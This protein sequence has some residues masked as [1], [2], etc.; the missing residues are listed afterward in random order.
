MSPA[1]C[2]TCRSCAREVNSTECDSKL[3]CSLCV[4]LSLCADDLREYERLWRKRDRYG[5][6]GASRSGPEDQLGRL[7]KRM[8]Q[9]LHERISDGRQAT[10]ILNAELERARQRATSSRILVRA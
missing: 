4:A 2:V 5:R 6:A 1:I 9:R 10:E 7:A 3:R 8:S